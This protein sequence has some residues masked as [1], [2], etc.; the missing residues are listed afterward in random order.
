VAT[1]SPR[2]SLDEHPENRET[3]FVTH[4]QDNP[5]PQKPANKDLG[6][7]DPR[8][9]LATLRKNKWLILSTTVVISAGVGFWSMGQPP[10]Y[11]AECV[12][13][14]EPSPSQPLEGAMEDVV[15]P[16]DSFW[17]A[18]E[19]FATQNRILKSRSLAERVVTKVGLHTDPAFFGVPAEERRTW[20]PATVTA[21]AA[22]LQERLTV[23]QENETRLVHVRVTDANAE[24]A[25]LVANAFCD[26]YI[27]KTME[28]RLGTAVS[29][30]NWLNTRLGDLNTHVDESERA[31]H[32][33][34]E[35]N[36]ILD[37]SMEVRQEI[38]AT[39]IRFFSEA[40]TKTRV[41]H[42]ELLARHRQLQSSL[43][44]NPLSVSASTLLQDEQ[45]G[46]LRQALHGKLAERDALGTRYSEEHPQLRA[47]DAQITALRSQLTTEIRTRV[48]AAALDLR[49][50]EAEERGLRGALE[51]ARQAGSEFN[52]LNS[53][54][55]RRNGER[56]NYSHL[57]TEVLQR[58]TE[59]G[60]AQQLR[61]ALASVVDRAIVPRSQVGPRTPLHVLLALVVGLLV[62][63]ALAYLRNSLDRTVRSAEHIE[64]LGLT[65][66]GVLPTFKRELN[67]KA[68]KSERDSDR[69][70]DLL[71]HQQPTS[72][73]A[74]C[75]RAIRTNLA[76]LGTDEPLR[77][78]VVASPGPQEGKT[79][80]ASTLAIVLVQ[81]GKRV[82][83]VDTDL[84]KPRLRRVF[85]LSSKDGVTTV[86][87]GEKR[88]T[89]AVQRTE[90][91]G[92]SVLTSGPL[93]PNPAELLHTAR[94]REL[95]REAQEVFDIVILDSPPL[96]VVT[97]A[98]LIAA[99]V[100]G[101]LLVSRM[102]Q[103]SRVALRQV[104][105]QLRGVGASIVGVVLNDADLSTDG[106]E[107]SRY[108]YY[109]G[110]E[111]RDISTD[112]AA[113]SPAAAD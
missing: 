50:V 76:F 92:L 11:E 60:L 96:G 72:A 1:D 55:A 90:I 7:W 98:V 27:D 71:V 8:V 39:R 104:T 74:E 69:Q 14:Y 59:I 41:R 81:A 57:R 83:L 66:L 15:A 20:R 85:G 26:V 53:E 110:T 35:Q 36:G 97:D 49:E 99:Q 31:L 44:D 102:R 46:T 75:A 67:G 43:A 34:R 73:V 87:L 58:S 100:K 32:T 105:A 61:V 112:E 111:Y 89:E 48:E 79:T 2:G 54:Y 68:L 33:F 42:I 23:E 30:F 107:Y 10:V 93:A 88:L 95:L 101:T 84:R 12:L 64:D 4:P 18:Q 106:Y 51:E 17:L 25:T 108:Y 78:I 103:T 9:L 6:R 86:L 45:V 52:Q 3:H 109:R 29:A 56:E 5:V 28:D 77:S 24:R 21:A 40:L 13:Q 47:L 113:T 37:V 19:F 38:L 91:P 62:G 65:V 22:R 16:V 82:L 70:N 80:M 94:F 63:C